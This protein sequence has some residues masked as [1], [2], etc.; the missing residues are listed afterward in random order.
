[1]AAITGTSA[2]SALGTT[3][4]QA[5]PG[6]K[7]AP[8][9]YVP[10]AEKG[11]PSGVAVLDGSAKIPST[12]LPDLSS[13][14]A[15]AGSVDARKHG[16]PISGTADASPA[17]N[18]AAHAARTA[19]KPL[20]IPK[21]TIYIDS[22]VNMRNLDVTCEAAI[23]VR[24]T[25]AVGVVVG[26][27]STQRNAR[28]IFLA[29]VQ[30]AG[31][32][33]AMW[34]W[35]Y[36]AI[37]VIGLKNGTVG[38][39]NCSL[40]ELYADASKAT[41]NSVAYNTFEIQRINHIRLWGE[42]GTA[43]VNENVFV[44]GS[45]NRVTIGGTYPHNHNKWVKLSIEGST[46]MI[47]IQNGSQN[48]FEDARAEGGTQVKFGASTW[49][50]YVNGMFLPNANVIAPPFVVLEDLGQQNEVTSRDL[51]Q[52]R[53]HTIFKIDG[54][55]PLF[56]TAGA[57]LD[58]TKPMPIPAV[59]RGKLAVRQQNQRYIDTGLMKIEE[60]RNTAL[61][62]TS[63]PPSR[64]TRFVFHSDAVILRPYVAAYDINGVMIDANLTPWAAPYGGLTAQASG[65]YGFGTSVSAMVLN[66]TSMAVKY[67]SF[68]AL[69]SLA[70]N[71][72]FSHITLTA[73]V[74]SDKQPGVIESM[75]NVVNRPLFG[76]AKPAQGLAWP[77]T[78]VQGPTTAWK[79]TARAETTLSAQAMAGIA[80][81]VAS[82]TGMA[83]GDVVGVLQT[84][85]RTHWT[86][87]VA[88][89]GTTI[90]LA[91]ATTA[92]AA[93]GAAVGTTRWV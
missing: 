66:V 47:D 72:L 21:G 16:L 30:H 69:T 57:H 89:A 4:A 12:Q 58:Q 24:H 10:L 20:Y 18:A 36:P 55:T 73:Y 90:T 64:V 34:D 53:A 68:S 37:C 88:I 14:Y 92:T 54:S 8:N 42:N 17:L 32:T 76:T 50:N 11:A 78:V 19:G 7:P 77:G 22:T 87:I 39:G 84:D 1:M 23:V 9:T 81:S 6:D 28:R 80:I 75:R 33:L 35:P 43:W 38:I 79:A 71:P 5:A 86:R 2:I 61:D 49:K 70:T 83:V 60:A 65:E 74:P 62:N 56:D 26:D 3:S 82:A 13:T 27:V 46:S 93:A 67:L 85:G 48:L 91:A 59:G 29:S 25:N 31:T 52:H 51:I 63:A 45:S 15:L 41:D 40:L 44:G